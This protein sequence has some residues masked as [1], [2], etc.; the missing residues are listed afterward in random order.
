LSVSV[1]AENLYRILRDA[2]GDIAGKALRKRHILV[3]RAPVSS[4]DADFRLEGGRPL[5]VFGHVGDHEGHGLMLGNGLCQKS[6]VRE[7]TSLRGPSRTAQFP[8]PMTQL[9]G[10]TSQTPSLR[11]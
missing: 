1:T 10:A 3:L 8:Q 6:C 7:H 9:L 4:S 5:D 2:D 11:F